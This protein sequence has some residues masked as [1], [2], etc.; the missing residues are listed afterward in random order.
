MKQSF[1]LPTDHVEETISSAPP[2]SSTSMYTE[3]STFHGKDYSTSANHFQPPPVVTC[4]APT[5]SQIP[6]Q[7]SAP[8]NYFSAPMSD[9]M[10]SPASASVMTSPAIR[11]LSPPSHISESDRLAA[12]EKATKCCKFAMSSLQYEDIITARQYLKEALERIQNL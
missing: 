3:D 8:A 2:S 9:Q 12:I 6:F 7:A 10:T 5:Y 1:N 11:D 4:H